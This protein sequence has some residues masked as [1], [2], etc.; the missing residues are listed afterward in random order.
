MTVSLKFKRQYCIQSCTCC[1]RNE[2]S[3]DIA[4]NIKEGIRIIRS[5]QRSRKTDWR[6]RKK[7]VLFVRRH[8]GPLSVSTSA[9]DEGFESKSTEGRQ[10][11]VRGSFQVHRRG[12]G[13]RSTTSL[14][15]ILLPEVINGKLQFSSF[16]R[17][18]GWDVKG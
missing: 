17:P 1:V 10:P 8:N 4:E 3:K 11:A 13:R 7:G 12:S 15:D 16:P 18:T 5:C 2:T 9:T 14:S 6:W